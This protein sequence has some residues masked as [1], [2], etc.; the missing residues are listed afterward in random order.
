MERGTKII[1]FAA[2]LSFLAIIIFSGIFFVNMLSRLGDYS[3][4]EENTTSN[5]DWM[6]RYR[7][8]N[9]RQ[10]KNFVNVDPEIRSLALSIV[11]DTPKTDETVNKKY[12][13]YPEGYIHIQ[14]Y[15][16]KSAVIKG[17]ITTDMNTEPIELYLLDNSNCNNFFAGRAFTYEEK[18]EIKDRINL[19]MEIKRSDYWCIVVQNPSDKPLDYA[20]IQL[21]LEIQNKLPVNTNSDIWKIWKIHK[22]LQDNINYVSDP[23]GKEYIAFPNETV[24]L[25]SGDCEDFGIL[26]SSLYEAVGL[27]AG[28][29]FVDTDGDGDSDH[30]MGIVYYPGNS[31]QF[32]S[33]EQEILGLNNIKSPSGS[34]KVLYFNPVIFGSKYTQGIW[35]AVDPLFIQY[36][37]MVGYIDHTPYDSVYFLDVGN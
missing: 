5:Q 33:Q 1:I 16:G 3:Q 2:V 27:D 23:L 32:I 19:N 28:V 17:N 20:N 13:I 22:W 37:D 8:E 30:L 29:V 14:Y 11:G 35:V 15:M 9:Y 25:K 10:I 34:V 6:D 18:R 21:N 4:I 31:S 24:S 26:A 12:I 36:K 7:I